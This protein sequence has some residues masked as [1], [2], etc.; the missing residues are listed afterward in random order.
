MDGDAHNI[1]IIERCNFTR[2][3]C[4]SGGSAVSFVSNARVDQVTDEAIIENW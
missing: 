2:N 3:S 4:L 1:P